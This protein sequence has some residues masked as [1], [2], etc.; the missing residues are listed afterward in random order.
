MSPAPTG[1]LLR[2]RSPPVLH[3][4][5][6]PP[7]ASPPVLHLRGSGTDGSP[8]RAVASNRD[9]DESSDPGMDD[10]TVELS[11]GAESQDHGV[12]D[13]QI[14]IRPT[15]NR[16]RSS[17]QFCW[18]CLRRVHNALMSAHYNN[19]LTSSGH[20]QCP[21][22]DNMYN[23]GLSWINRHARHHFLPYAYRCNRCGTESQT[24]VSIQRS[25][26]FKKK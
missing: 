12:P 25:A 10:T 24:R 6:R 1:R 26:F 19:H 11:S 5:S 17:H 4:G 9:D 21:V 2:R 13:G 22:C 14:R 16:A 18:I 23:R 15:S 7:P 8:R 3:L 20:A